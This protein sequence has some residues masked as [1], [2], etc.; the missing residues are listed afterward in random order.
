MVENGILLSDFAEVTSYGELWAR[1]RKNPFL[2]QISLSKSEIY[3]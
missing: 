1:A 2:F 3:Y